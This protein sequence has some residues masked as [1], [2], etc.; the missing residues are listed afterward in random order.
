VKA[1]TPPA[2]AKKAARSIKVAGIDFDPKSKAESKKVESITKEKV[3]MEEYRG[4]FIITTTAAKG[5]QHVK[6]TDRR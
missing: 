1:A 5:N 2:Q 3:E 6:L 4:M